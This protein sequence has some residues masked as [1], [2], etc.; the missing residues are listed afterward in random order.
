[1]HLRAHLR[2]R[3]GPPRQKAAVGRGSQPG[4]SGWLLLRLRGFSSSLPRPV[5]G[6]VL[7]ATFPHSLTTRPQ[8]AGSEGESAGIA[9]AR[10]E[11]R[12]G[13]ECLLGRR[14]RRGPL[15]ALQNPGEAQ[16]LGRVP[17]SCPGVLDRASGPSRKALECRWTEKWEPQEETVKRAAVYLRVST[18]DQHLETQ[19]HD[20]QA[21]AE[22]RGFQAVQVYEDRSSG[23]RASRPG[24]DQLLADA[25]RGKF[26]VLDELNHLGIEFVSFREQLDTGGPLGRAMVVIISAIAELERNLIV[27]RVKAGLR[28]A[29]LEGR[30]IGRPSL[31]VDR[32]ALGRDRERGLSLTELAELHHVSK[33]TVSRALNQAR[34]GV[35]KP[36]AQPPPQAAGS[37]R[38]ETAV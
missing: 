13:C 5:P 23:A 26:Q 7:P 38:A 34:R 31:G 21:L 24:L 1:M 17:K 11:H 19:L 33:S 35:P 36:L 20:L 32:E 15:E 4:K 16:S 28:R 12:R 14:F 25:R 10:P 8:P 30:R 29:R 6:L 22:S 18:L 2:A 27:E 37:T 9:R 3:P